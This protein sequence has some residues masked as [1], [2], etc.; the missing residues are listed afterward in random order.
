MSTSEIRVYIH[1]L[2]DEG[3][4]NIIHELTDDILLSDLY[5]NASSIKILSV[6]DHSI[7]HH[8]AFGLSNIKVI[9][10]SDDKSYCEFPTL[11]MLYDDCHNFDGKILYLHTKGATKDNQQTADWRRYMSY[12]NVAMWRKRRLELD[13]FDTTGVNLLGD[14]KN[15]SSPIEEWALHPSSAPLHYSGN[16]WWATASHVRNLPDPMVGYAPSADWLRWRHMCEMWVCNRK[17]AEHNSAWQSNIDHYY[18]NYPKESYIKEELQ[19]DY[20]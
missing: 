5:R 19:N 9:E 16:F 18:S 2:S 3:S 8:G 6:G 14:K 7:A 17:S 12:F 13:L 10:Y 20:D 1:C 11:K 15:Y 4:K